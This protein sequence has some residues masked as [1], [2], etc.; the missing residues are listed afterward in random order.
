MLSVYRDSLLSS[1]TANRRKDVDLD[2]A[3]YPCAA[4]AAA[5]VA[6]KPKIG[7]DRHRLLELAC[8]SKS[9]LHNLVKDVIKANGAEKKTKKGEG[10]SEE[11]S[12]SPDK[13]SNGR[14]VYRRKREED[15]EN[16]ESP[17]KAAAELTTPASPLTPKRNI[18]RPSTPGSARKT[19][20]LNQEELEF[21]REEYEEWKQRMLVLAGM[22]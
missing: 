18:S 1:L 13:T 14:R 19:P 22:A 4:V 16:G 8:A 11:E 6:S 21:D 15:K 17:V 12:Q 5:C 10:T 7:F 3:K 9:E 20:R 2:R